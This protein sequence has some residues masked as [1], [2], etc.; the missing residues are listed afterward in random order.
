M[1][2][3]IT[4]GEL[5]HVTYHVYMLITEHGCLPKKLNS[6]IAIICFSKSI[7]IYDV[8]MPVAV[9]VQASNPMG[10]SDIV[11]FNSFAQLFVQL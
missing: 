8:C 9:L 4:L 2:D 5:Q 7:I 10:T 3:F 1:L 6:Y 11:S